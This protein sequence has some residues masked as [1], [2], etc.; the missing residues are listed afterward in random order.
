MLNTVNFQIPTITYNYK[1]YANIFQR[2]RF[3]Q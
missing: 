2:L 1:N 3:N